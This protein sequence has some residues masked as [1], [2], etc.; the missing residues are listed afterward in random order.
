MITLAV[1]STVT[2]TTRSESKRLSSAP[3]AHS[4]QTTPSRQ[5]D[6][7]VHFAASLLHLQIIQHTFSPSPRA[8]GTQVIF[9]GCMHADVAWLSLCSH[10]SVP[11]K[12][13]QVLILC[14]GYGEQYVEDIAYA[15]RNQTEPNAKMERYLMLL[16]GPA[17]REYVSP[18]LLT[19]NG[20]TIMDYWTFGLEKVDRVSPV[21]ENMYIVVNDVEEPRYTGFGGW[22]DDLQG[23]LLRRIGFCTCQ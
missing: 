11:C 10:P 8:P 3:R 2:R 19:V 14:G 1:A 12:T 4:L 20:E 13:S 23:G 7:T 15:V 17:G 6:G 22:I 9:F 5:V 21:E 18:G 16:H